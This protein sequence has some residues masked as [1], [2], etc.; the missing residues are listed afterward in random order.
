[1]EASEARIIAETHLTSNDTIT[2]NHILELI[3]AEA[4]EGN[5]HTWYYTDISDRVTEKLRDL[6]YI[7]KEVTERNEINWEISW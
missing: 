1:M 7:L 3:E 6:G 5:F 2:F 4:K